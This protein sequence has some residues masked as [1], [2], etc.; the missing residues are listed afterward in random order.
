MSPRLRRAFPTPES[1]GDHLFRD[2]EEL[3][4]L[5]TIGWRRRRF[6]G[7]DPGWALW[8]RPRGDPRHGD[9]TH[10]LYVSP[11]LDDTRA[12]LSAVMPVLTDS[13]ALGFKVGAELPYL[14]RSDKLVLYFAGRAELVRVARA[15]EPRLTALACHGVPFTC[16]CGAAGLLS[17]GTDPP[18]TTDHS[19][20]SWLAGNLARAMTGAGPGERLPAALQ[21]VGA[22]GVDPGTWEPLDVD[23]E[24]DAP[25]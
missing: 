18:G 1:V 17:W 3:R 8:T 24:R 20:R 7:E 23:W 6:S 5:L 21:R 15:I 11:R 16:A 25:D 13:E 22:L 9:A 14:A 19:W 12:A 10:K 4:R 2:D